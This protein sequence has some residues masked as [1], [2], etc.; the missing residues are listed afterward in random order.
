MIQRSIF[1]IGGLEILVNLLETNDIQ[2]QKGSLT[3]L[4][5]LSAFNEMRHHLIDLG[6]VTPLIDLLKHPAK[7]IQI[8][9]TETL[10]NIAMKRKARK[11]FR[12]RGGIPLIVRDYHYFDCRGYYYDVYIGC[13]S[14]T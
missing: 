4:L 14:W 9:A 2:C 3:I 7:D 6:I 13:C 11:Q 10:A 8:L 12:I 5:S 1:R